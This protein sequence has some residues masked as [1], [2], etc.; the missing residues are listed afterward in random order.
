[1][2]WPA[3]SFAHHSPGAGWKDASSPSARSSHATNAP[4]DMI[5]R[6]TCCGV[7]SFVAGP[8]MCCPFLSADPLR[9]RGQGVRERRLAAERGESWLD[10]AVDDRHAFVVADERALHRVD[11]EPLHIREPEPERR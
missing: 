10:A 1:M 2:M 7:R 9:R 4:D 3:T 11:R 5:S 6:A 8:L